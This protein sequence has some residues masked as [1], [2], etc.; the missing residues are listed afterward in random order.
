MKPNAKPARCACG[1]HSALMGR[2]HN[3]PLP[4]GPRWDDALA[5]P[6]PPASPGVTHKPT[7]T[8][9]ASLTNV[10]H[11]APA[12][13]SKAAERQARYRA[14][15]GDAYKQRHR[16]LMRQKRASQRK[17]RAAA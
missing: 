6:Q 5:K 3:C 13:K 12:T 7:V 8:H 11:T 2:V 15:L 10:T 14:K 17:A 9:G 1:Y 4:G 16:D